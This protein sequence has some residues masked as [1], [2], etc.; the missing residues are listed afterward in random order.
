[1]SGSDPNQN[2]PGPDQGDPIHQFG[3]SAPEQYVLTIARHYFATFAMPARHDWL[4]GISKAL[5]FFGHDDGP[6]VAVAVLS[7]VQ[8]MRRSR[9]SDFR[10]SCPDC[11]VCAQ[12]V[13][14]HE[15]LLLSAIRAAA[16]GRME[17]AK[18]YANLLCEGNDTQSFVRALGTLA[19]RAF[20]DLVM[21]RRLQQARDARA[22]E[23]NTGE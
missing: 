17:A 1:M 6:N 13:T 22:A 20:P 3:Y 23:L 16:R 9:V 15:Q 11:P 18:A 19:H 21:T 7:T 2:C 8:T 10:F 12:Y 14:Q 5:S 4:S